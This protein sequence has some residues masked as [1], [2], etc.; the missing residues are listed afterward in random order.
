[1][2]QRGDTTEEVWRITAAQIFHSLAGALVVIMTMKSK[3]LRNPNKI[4]IQTRKNIITNP[5]CPYKAAL[6]SK[7]EM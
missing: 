5:L 2:I 4:S 3:Q 1:M 6:T 7:K